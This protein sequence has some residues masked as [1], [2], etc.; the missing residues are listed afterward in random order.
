MERI[1]SKSKDSEKPAVDESTAG[2]SLCVVSS[3]GK[4]HIREVVMSLEVI[5]WKDHF[6]QLADL[7]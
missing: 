6:E 3:I 5:E 1:C 7:D 4:S 2:K